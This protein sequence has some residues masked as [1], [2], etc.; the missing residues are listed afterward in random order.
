MIVTSK[1]FRVDSVTGHETIG[2]HIDECIYPVHISTFN[3]PN[4]QEFFAS[5]LNF[6]C[7]NHFFVLS[8]QSCGVTQKYS[9]RQ[10]LERSFVLETIFI[11]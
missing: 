9:H 6:G 8:Y 4:A 3:W 7:H 2:R 5:Q 1:Y 11:K 10:I